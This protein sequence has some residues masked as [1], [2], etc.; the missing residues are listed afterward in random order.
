MAP[1]DP[2][3]AVHGARY[4]ID[5]RLITRMQHVEPRAIEIAFE[6]TI[7]ADRVGSQHADA[8]KRWKSLPQMRHERGHEIGDRQRHVRREF[9]DEGVTEK[10]R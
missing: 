1:F 7:T 6:K 8:A 10:A 4:A 9:V 5:T 3:I 2:L